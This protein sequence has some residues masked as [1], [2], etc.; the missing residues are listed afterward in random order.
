M[1]YSANP[2]EL[3]GESKLCSKFFNCTLDKVPLSLLTDLKAGDILFI[4]GSHLFM[5]GTDLEII[6]LQVLPRLP[7]GVY[8]HLHDIFLPDDYPHGEDWDWWGFN[9]QALLAV[10]LTSGGYEPVI[11]SAYL[12]KYHPQILKAINAPCHPRAY[13]S[14]FWLIKK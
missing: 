1:L 14:S 7:K 10:L 2:K 13:E 9:E 6:F 5:K 3:H 11:S 12:R 8:I 4:D